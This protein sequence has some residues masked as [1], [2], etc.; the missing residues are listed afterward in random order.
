MPVLHNIAPVR[1]KVRNTFRLSAQGVNLMI[2]SAAKP[3][4]ISVTVLLHAGSATKFL[5]SMQAA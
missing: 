4:Y 2:Y 1:S 5:F 3:Q